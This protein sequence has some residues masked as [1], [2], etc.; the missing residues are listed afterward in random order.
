MAN[1]TQMLSYHVDTSTKQR[2]HQ[3]RSLLVRGQIKTHSAALSL[4]AQ[5]QLVAQ[6]QAKHQKNWTDAFLIFSS[7]NFEAIPI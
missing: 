3:L 5:G 6:A 1:S 2:I 7:I 4:N